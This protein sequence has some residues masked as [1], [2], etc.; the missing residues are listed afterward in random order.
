MNK[1]QLELKEAPVLRLLLKYSIP[2][3]VGMIVNALYNVVDR[4]FIGNMVKDPLAMSAV[5]LT[6]PFVLVI[7]GFC[8]LIGIGGS[9]RISIF[10]GEN[11]PEKANHILGNMLSLIVGLM[12][13]ITVIGSIFKVPILYFLGASEDT[14]FYASEY[15]QIILLG[16]VFQGLSYCFNT[17]MRAEGNP[18]KAM[19]TMLIGAGANIILDPIFIGFFGLGIAGAAW[20]TILSQA[21]SMT[22][23]LSHYFTKESV[24]KFQRKYFRLRFDIVKGIISIGMAPFLVQIASGSISAIANNTLRFYG[25][26][27]A[28][29]AMAI[30]NSIA[31][32][33]MMPVFGINQGSQPII[34]F[35]YGAK[36][37]HRSKQ[38]WKLAALGATAICTLGFLIVQL[39]PYQLLRAFTPNPELIS[40]GVDGM[41]KLLIL[42]P[43]VGFQV[44]S[45]NYFQAIGK[46]TKSMIL[47]MLRQVIILIPLMLILPNFWKINGIWFAFP[48][49][50]I[51]SSMITGILIFREMKHLR[52]LSN[53]QA[54]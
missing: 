25:G 50:D 6:F 3:I 43:I 35:N 48:M 24:L 2:A 9:S 34:G 7:F 37:Y 10:L 38:A 52:E 20:A 5:G 45:A 23:V 13:S 36:Q 26:D 17:T 42:L 30:V 32:F 14:I 49:A 8:M 31:A 11:N 4:M 41:R 18:K 15:I 54:T 16:S 46:A 12:L 22:W 53:Q 27:L 21:I 29:G 39:F 44:V 33:I 47:S 28:I 19:L 1:K 51:C 40:I